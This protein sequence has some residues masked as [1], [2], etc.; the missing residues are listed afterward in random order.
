M[1]LYM[2]APCHVYVCACMYILLIY[3][4]C[5]MLMAMYTFTNDIIVWKYVLALQAL[6]SVSE[7]S[8]LLVAIARPSATVREILCGMTQN[9]CGHSHFVLCT[10]SDTN[11]CLS[12]PWSQA[13]GPHGSW[14][15]GW[16][17]CLR[18]GE[19]SM[20]SMS[21]SCMSSLYHTLCTTN[22]DVDVC[23]PI[24][25]INVA[26]SRRRGVCRCNGVTYWRVTRD[27]AG[28]FRS[29]PSAV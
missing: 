1:L 18:L 21:S 15:W 27:I 9:M 5:V 7:R 24:S 23:M 10:F 8:D 16:F 3:N 6:R 12:P 28:G 13:T 25:G 4:C 2:C 11:S 17:S 29:R 20:W 26:S 14:S 19:C 22:T